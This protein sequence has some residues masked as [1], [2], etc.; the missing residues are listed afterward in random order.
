MGNPISLDLTLCTRRYMGYERFVAHWT[1]LKN[2][3][4]DVGFVAC[5]LG[6]VRD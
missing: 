2:E 4:G 1:P 6:S 3:V 5:T